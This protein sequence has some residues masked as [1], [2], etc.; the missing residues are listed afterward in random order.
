MK[1]LFITKAS[2][3]ILFI[4]ISTLA[5]GAVVVKQLKGNAFMIFDTKTQSLLVGDHVPKGAEILTE[6]GTEL[7][8]SNYYNHQFHI[9]GSSHLK[10]HKKSTI[11]YEGYLW[12]RATSKGSGNPQE[13][14]IKTANGIIQYNNTEGI[15]SFDPHNKKTQFL[16]LRGNNVFFNKVYPGPRYEIKAGMFSFIDS[17]N[18]RGIP[19]RPSY[20]GA[21]SYKKLITLFDGTRSLPPIP[22]SMNKMPERKIASIDEQ[23]N[24]KNMLKAHALK[25]EAPSTGPSPI[26]IN[27]YAPSS[28]NTNPK[29][30]PSLNLTVPKTSKRPRPTVN[31][32]PASRPTSKNINPFERALQSRYKEKMRHDKELNTLID[33]LKSI[34]KDY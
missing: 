14:D 24:F 19:H 18:N 30:P 21:K 2:L 9:A 23:Y 7:T 10:V 6:E 15:V 31:R 5:Q 1:K 34:K 28:Y 11:L 26:K 4:F 29:D 16:G 22:G 25:K 27:I 20:I 32:L 8:L 12:F 13:F 33:A 3:M 17:N